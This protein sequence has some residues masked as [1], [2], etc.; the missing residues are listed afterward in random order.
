MDD[1]KGFPGSHNLTVTTHVL[2]PKVLPRK[3]CAGDSVIGHMEYTK[4]DK[5][6]GKKKVTKQKQLLS[7]LY[8]LGPKKSIEGRI[9]VDMCSKS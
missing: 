1:I 9:S 7:G 6:S 5:G 2:L 4:E 8:V 3:N